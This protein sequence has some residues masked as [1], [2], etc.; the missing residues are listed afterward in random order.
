MK[1]ICTFL[2]A[3]IFLAAISS[4]WVSAA[5]PDFALADSVYVFNT[6]SGV[7]L[8]E[9][10]SDKLT[11]PTSTVKLMTAIIACEH[12]AGRYDAELTVTKEALDITEG[13]NVGLVADET[14]TADALLTALIAGGANDAANVFALEIG[15]TLEGF[16]DMMNEKAREIGAENTVYKNASGIDAQGM[17]T[18]ARD[19]ALITEYAYKIPGFKEYA[20]VTRY[21]MPATNKSRER[22]VHNR[23]YLL[24]YHIEPKYYDPDAI[25][26]NSGYTKEGG[27]CTV[28]VAEK[29]GLTY[30]IAIMNAAK[31][32]N[33]DNSSF[34]LAS[35]LI[36]FATGNF[37]YK[38]V[39]DPNTIVHEMPVTLAKNVDYVIVSPE[40]KVEYF[41][42]RATDIESAISHEMHFESDTLSAPIYEGQR[43]GH[44]DVIY[45]GEAIA[46][47]P[48]VSKNN[49]SAST[50][51]RLF[52]YLKSLLKSNQVRIAICVFVLLFVSYLL[53]SY[54]QFRRMRNRRR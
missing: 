44:V 34:Y 29:N 52:D 24:S 42:P 41:L 6:D 5:E 47:V 51:L 30:I 7:M 4:I 1:K 16:C 21:V 48:L 49:V 50:F 22:V 35:E 8:C 39:L 3:A 20:S 2:L 15:G 13:N 53:L 45:N 19:V 40:N 32:E 10:N 54:A 43:V 38:T 37:E 28:T 9:K 18:T 11:P 17:V 31:D 12:F 14:V 46:T 26:M 33:G 25:G 23:N 36:D 27:F